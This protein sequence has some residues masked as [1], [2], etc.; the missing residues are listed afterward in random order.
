MPKLRICLGQALA[1][2]LLILALGGT[3]AIA[4]PLDSRF[5]YQGEL[6]QSGIPANGEFDFEFQPF[7]ALS[8]GTATAPAQIIENVQVANGVFSVELDFGLQTF[9][10]DKVWLAVGVREGASSGGFTGLL[11]RQALNATP[12]AL[13]SE[14]VAANAVGSAE[15]IDG[16]VAAIDI[17]SSEVQRRVVGSCAVGSAITSISAT[18]TVSCSAPPSPVVFKV[19]GSGFAVKDLPQGDSVE[20]DLWEVVAFNVGGGFNP[21]TRRFVAPSTGYYYL[22]ATVVQSNTTTSST[23]RIAFNVSGSL[24]FTRTFQSNYPT[25]S[26]SGVFRLVA[27]QEVFVRMRNFTTG[28]TTRMDGSGSWF[29]GYKISD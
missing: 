18:G 23:F 14:M 20:A 25:T 8:A 2:A 27:G 1:A 3:R 26:L 29:E 21:T 12:Y 5:T 28:S 6:R 7:N 15:L 24:D 4:E 17:N 16:S 22:H 19:R 11:P 13:H 9:V 10:G